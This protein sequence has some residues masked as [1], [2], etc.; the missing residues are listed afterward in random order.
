[1]FIGIWNYVSYAWFSVLLMKPPTQPRGSSE[2]RGR[3][4]LGET[5]HVYLIYSQI[6]TS[7][8]IKYK[9]IC[10]RKFLTQFCIPASEFWWNFQLLLQALF[11]TILSLKKDAFRCHPDDCLYYYYCYPYIAFTILSVIL[12]LPSFVL[13]SCVWL[14][15]YFWS[16]LART[17]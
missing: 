4:Q 14:L 17:V 16:S 10:F 15:A 2:V 1:M 8:V 13:F 7:Y 3:N 6:I 12:S 5:R 11:I 9:G